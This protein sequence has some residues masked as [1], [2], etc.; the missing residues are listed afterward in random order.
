MLDMTA[1]TRREAANGRAFRRTRSTVQA[2]VSTPN[3]FP[4][5]NVRPCDGEDDQAWETRNAT[6]AALSHST[7]WPPPGSKS[8]SSRLA[9]T[10]PA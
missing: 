1:K 5:T 4:G 9:A 3:V 10:A 2:Y 8:Q 7:T 6:I